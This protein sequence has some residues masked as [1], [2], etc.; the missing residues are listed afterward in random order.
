MDRRA[1]TTMTQIAAP[2]EE[3]D[4]RHQQHDCQSNTQQHHVPIQL[5]LAACAFGIFGS[6]CDSK[7][8]RVIG[9]D[10]LMP[11]IISLCDA[12]MAI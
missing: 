7:V 2:F 3:T 8:V 1:I 12:I 10:C 5:G 4:R 6:L 9:F 11:T